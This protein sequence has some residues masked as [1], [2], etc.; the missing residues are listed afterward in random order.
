MYMYTNVFIFIQGYKYVNIK[1]N[2][3]TLFG[4]ASPGF[5]QWRPPRQMMTN[6]LK[7]AAK[8]Y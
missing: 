3:F 5:C 2:I 8:I 6:S 7:V 4:A 1:H